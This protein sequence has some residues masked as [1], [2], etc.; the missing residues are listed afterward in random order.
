MKKNLLRLALLLL[1]LAAVPGAAQQPDKPFKGH[2]RNAENGIELHLDLYEESLQAPGLSFLGKMHGYLNGRIY[3]IWLLVSHE[4]KGNTATLRFSNDQG[5]DSQTVQLT[6]ENDS[7]FT[8][9]AVK[10]NNIRRV[11]NR[12]LVKIPATLVFRRK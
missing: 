12:K 3:G 7:T 9:T 6:A 8:Y 1:V 4:I 5:A 10:G 2:F 11:E